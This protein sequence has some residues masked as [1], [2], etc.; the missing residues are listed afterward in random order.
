MTSVNSVAHRDE[1]DKKVVP[2]YQPSGSG[3]FAVL[4]LATL[5]AVGTLDRVAHLVYRGKGHLELHP[6]GDINCDPARRCTLLACDLATQRATQRAT[7][8]GLV[9]RKPQFPSPSPPSHATLE[10]AAAAVAAALSL[11]C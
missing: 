3:F 11:E 5:P 9:P 4:L 1:P 6:A 7:L 10:A 8:V 2:A